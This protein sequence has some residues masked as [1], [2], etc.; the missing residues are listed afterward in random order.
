MNFML[1]YCLLINEYEY[2]AIILLLFF[3]IYTL[4]N[5]DFRK[6]IVLPIDYH[7]KWSDSSHLVPKYSTIRT[8]FFKAARICNTPVTKPKITFKAQA[9][10]M[11]DLVKKFG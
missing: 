4:I 3:H 10:Q 5:I 6:I 11:E 9:A 1:S 8:A 7:T 2:C